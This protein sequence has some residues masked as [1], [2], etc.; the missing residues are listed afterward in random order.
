MNLLGLWQTL[1]Q[2]QV[3]TGEPIIASLG[4]G[5]IPSHTFSTQNIFN[6]GLLCRAFQLAQQEI[7]LTSNQSDS[8]ALITRIRQ[9]PSI[10]SSAELASVSD[11]V[12][13]K[14]REQYGVKD[15]S[16]LEIT[17]EQ[18]REMQ[19]EEFRTKVERPLATLTPGNSLTKLTHGE[20]EATL[21]H[22]GELNREAAGK[23]TSEAVYT[24]NAPVID[25]VRRKLGATGFS[26]LTLS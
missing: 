24:A 9:D 11:M 21:F 13:A 17:D 1:T 26:A 16:V 22:L 19:E 3:P 18:Q 10:I 15:R 20:V 14:M 6:K 5:C 2:E 12:E 23:R 25:A 7:A 4:M 8:E